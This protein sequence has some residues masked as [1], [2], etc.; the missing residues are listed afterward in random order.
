M[1][2]HKLQPYRPTYVALIKH[3][4]LSSKYYGSYTILAKIGSVAYKLELPVDSNV[5]LVFHVSS[6]KKKVGS[7]IAVQSALPSIG[8]DSH[9]IVQPIAILQRHMIKRNNTVEVK[10]LVQWFNLPPEDATWEV[11]S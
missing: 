8:E 2:Y 6:L 10:V 3:L 11:Y 4:K 5:H 7:S 1:V 9:F